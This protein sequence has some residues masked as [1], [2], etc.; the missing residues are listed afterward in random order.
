MTAV[1]TGDWSLLWLPHSGEVAKEVTSI[2]G[3]ARARQ[4]HQDERLV[5]TCDHHVSIR[6]LSHGKYVR[7]HVGT[8][9][10]SEH[11]YDLKEQRGWVM[12]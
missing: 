3:L 12:C 7:G 9:T 8:T 2:E 10:T 6:L 11:V 4:A 5:L 1:L